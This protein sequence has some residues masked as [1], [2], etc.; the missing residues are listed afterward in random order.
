MR[1]VV[2]FFVSGVAFLV[3]LGYS[4]HMFVGGL[5]APATERLLIA[6]AVVLGAVVFVAL[7]RDAL[8]KRNA[9]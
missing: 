8:R 7:L 6:A 3:I 5:V 9:K 2:L 4:V 1:E